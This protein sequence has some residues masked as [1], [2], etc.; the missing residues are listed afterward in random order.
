MRLIVGV[1]AA[2]A[3][4]G[5]SGAAFAQEP[6]Q[7][8]S[9]TLR[10]GVGYELPDDE[11]G[12]PAIQ[13]SRIDTALTF[14]VERDDLSASLSYLE[15]DDNEEGYG[16]GLK[17]DNE[18]CPFF[19]E[20]RQGQYGV[21]CN[22]E[23][24]YRDV[25]NEN[26]TSVAIGIGG[27]IGNWVKERDRFRPMWSFGG[28][29]TMGDTSESTVS[30]GAELPYQ[31]SEDWSVT[32]GVNAVYGFESDRTFPDWEIAFEYEVNNNFAVSFGYASQVGIDDDD[33]EELDTERAAFVQLKY[34]F[35]S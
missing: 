6:S 8:Y 35:G 4:W 27:K 7:P 23:V 9:V 17:Y 19:G 33:P 30:A 29:T 16:L 5:A 13:R 34:S 10:S 32:A 24:E 21:G 15:T 18:H 14:A 20:V 12:I 11:L 1:A 22:L 25:G 2:L 26:S 31:L 3:L 28:S